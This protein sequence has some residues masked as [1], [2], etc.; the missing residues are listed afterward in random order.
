LLEEIHDDND[1]QLQSSF[2]IYD[3]CSGIR[4]L[5][6]FVQIMAIIPRDYYVKSGGPDECQVAAD[7]YQCGRDLTP[8]S[9]KDI[10]NRSKG[11]NTVVSYFFVSRPPAVV[12]FL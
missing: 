6:F 3:G 10:F 5:F 4:I 2:Q 1:D 11:N 9:T 7:I 12:F 8:K